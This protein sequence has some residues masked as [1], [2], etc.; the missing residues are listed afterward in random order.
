MT[1]NQPETETRVCKVCAGIKHW[2]QFYPNETVCY[3]CKEEMG[4]RYCDGLCEDEKSLSEFNGKSTLCKRCIAEMDWPLYYC[5]KKHAPWNDVF[6]KQRSDNVGDMYNDSL[7]SIDSAIDD[8]TSF[9]E[10]VNYVM[11]EMLDRMHDEQYPL[12]VN[13]I[14][15]GLVDTCLSL[16]EHI[17]RLKRCTK[18]EK[19]VGSKNWIKIHSEDYQAWWLGSRQEIGHLDSD[20]KKSL[21]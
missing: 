2:N 10:F 9:F 4:L 16:A 7:H 20:I 21:K 18:M 17:K 11:A 19:N 6:P 8:G 3:L 1:I 13:D 14:P 12:E 5:N 15:D